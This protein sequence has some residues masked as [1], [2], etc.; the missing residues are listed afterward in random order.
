MKILRLA[1]GVL[2][3]ADG[4]ERADEPELHLRPVQPRI[5]VLQQARIKF[6]RVG[7]FARLI[8]RLGDFNLRLQNQ[9]LVI[10]QPVVFQ[11]QRRRHHRVKFRQRQAVHAHLAENL[12]LPQ[13]H[14][15]HGLVVRPAVEILRINGLRAR[16]VVLRLRDRAEFKQRRFADFVRHI[17][18]EQPQKRRLGPVEPAGRFEQ[19]RLG[20]QTLEIRRRRVRLGRFRIGLHHRR[21]NYRRQIRDGKGVGAG[22]RGEKRLCR[23][24]IGGRRR[25]GL[26]HRFRA[27]HQQPENQGHHGGTFD[28]PAQKKLFHLFHCVL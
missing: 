10:I 1:G 26:H 16:Q 12:S 9:A 18:R 23:S 8:M 3:A 2:V 14:L 11:R 15:R 25:K 28:L 5:V 19:A 20:Q 22:Q 27:G 6:R 17:L 21:R 13:Q 4:H 24:R 7:E